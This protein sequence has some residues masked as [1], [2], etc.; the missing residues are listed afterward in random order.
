LSGPPDPDLTPYRVAIE[1]G[2]QR[3]LRSLT[4]AAR[5]RVNRFIESHLKVTP[6]GAYPNVKRLSGAYRDYWQF[7]VT[8][9]LRLIYRVYE[10]EHLV[11]VE[12]IGQHPEWRSLRPF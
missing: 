1:R 9:G 5:S 11:E 6:T 10:D 12:H 7:D 2:A 3:A 4:P 8:R